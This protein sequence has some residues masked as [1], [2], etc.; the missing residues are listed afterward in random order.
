MTRAALSVVGFC[1]TSWISPS[2][3]RK[4][5]PSAHSALVPSKTRA[6]EEEEDHPSLAAAT[7][8]ESSNLIVSD[9]EFVDRRTV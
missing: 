9:H 4:Y 3:T 7:A 8:F 5:M 6:F 2:E 1:E